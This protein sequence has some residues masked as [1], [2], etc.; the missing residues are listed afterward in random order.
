MGVAINW[1]NPKTLNEKLQWLKIYWRD[2]LATVCA[3]KYAVRDY[4]RDTIGEQY[5]NTLIGVYDTIDEIDINSLPDKFVLKATHGSS[6]NI[7]CSDKSKMNWGN[8]KKKLKRWLTTNYYCG[9]REWVYKNIKP[10]II[11][12]EYLGDN[13]VDYKL[14]CFNGEPRYWFVATDRKAGVKADYYELDWKKAPFRWI[15]PPLNS[16]PQKPQ[17]SDKMIELSKMLSKP[18]PFVRVDFYEI[19]G[20]IYFG[21]LTFFHG[22]GFGWYEPREYNEYLG[23]LLKLPEKAW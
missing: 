14:Y 7:I 6:M 21:E 1:D 9:N 17:N 13:I 5:L 20:K 18:F 19:N 12:E 2:P 4:V 16:P 23:Q 8:E 22:S 15:Y 11:C 3:D 10:R